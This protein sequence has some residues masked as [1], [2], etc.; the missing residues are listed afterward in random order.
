MKKYIFPINYDYLSKVLGIIEYKVL[1]PLAVLALVLISV[2]SLFNISFFVKF[3]IFISIFLPTFL[4]FNTSVNHEPFYVFIISV[5]K[6]QY[7]SS[8]YILKK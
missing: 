6:H 7:F 5:I 2:L 1:I 8:K 4:L 3:G